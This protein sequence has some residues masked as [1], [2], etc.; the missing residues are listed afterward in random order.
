[1]PQKLRERLVRVLHDDVKILQPPE[2]AAAH[3]QEADQVRMRELSS[4]PPVR[5]LPLGERWN[6]RNQLERGLR[7]VLCPVLGQEDPAVIGAADTTRQRKLPIDNL[8]LPPR[9]GFTHL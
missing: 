4:G 6:S 5:K 9:P 3:I 8:P 7:E 1:M 2:L